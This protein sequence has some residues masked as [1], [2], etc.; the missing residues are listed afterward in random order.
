M[1]KIRFDSVGTHSIGLRWSEPIEP[2]GVISTYFIA[3]SLLRDNEF[4]SDEIDICQFGKN[5]YN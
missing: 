4:L 3:Y 1:N 5:N 2:N